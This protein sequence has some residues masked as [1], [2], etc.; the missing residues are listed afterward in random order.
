MD[1]INFIIA[2][3]MPVSICVRYINYINYMCIADA[4]LNQIRCVPSSFIK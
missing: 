1:D 2:I 4:L 3:L